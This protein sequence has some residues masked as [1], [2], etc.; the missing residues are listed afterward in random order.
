L[1]NRKHPGCPGSKFA[2][3]GHP[4]FLET[5]GGRKDALIGK[6]RTGVGAV[7]RS[8]KVRLCHVGSQFWNT[9]S[10]GGERSPGRRKSTSGQHKEK[11]KRQNHMVSQTSK[12]NSRQGSGYR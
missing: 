8:E 7:F 10:W 4:P 2:A 6:G 3:K 5:A 1:D 12:L 11:Q 9:V